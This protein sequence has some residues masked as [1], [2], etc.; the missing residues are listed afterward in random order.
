MVRSTGKIF[1]FRCRRDALL[2][3]NL[4][5][6]GFG[7]S[8]NAAIQR[9]MVCLDPLECG[10]GRE[11]RRCGHRECYVGAVVP[12]L[13]AAALRIYSPRRSWRR[14]GQGPDAGLF[15]EASRPRLPATFAASTRQI[16]LV[17]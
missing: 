14:R 10:A 2:K 3:R 1:A 6:D 17:S 15:P 12:D 4:I 9:G 8:T 5:T 13:L 7:H 11:G 16:P